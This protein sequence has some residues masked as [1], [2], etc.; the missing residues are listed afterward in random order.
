MSTLRPFRN[1][2]RRFA[3]AALLLSLA[4]V[5]V[6]HPRPADRPSI[7]LALAGGGALG[8]AHLGVILELEEL[9]IPVDYIAGTSMGSVVGALY[10]TGYSG[11]QILAILEEIDW[12]ELFMAKPPRRSL[13]YEERR[14]DK[15]YMVD[16]GIQEGAI[17][18][19]S[20]ATAGQEITELLDELLRY[21]AVSDS[22]DRF[23]RPLR[24][25]ATDLATGEEVVYSS[26]DLKTAVRA[27]MAVPGIFTPVEYQG[28]LLIDGGWSNLLP[29]DAVRAMG[30]ERV[31]AVKLNELTIDHRELMPITEVIN[32]SSS[33][34]R[35]PKQMENLA[36]ADV[37]L[38][39]DVSDYSPAS[40]QHGME[41]VEAGRQAVREK[42]PELLFLRRETLGAAAALKSIVPPTQDQLVDIRRIEY[43]GER[44]PAEERATLARRFL[45]KSWVS[46]IQSATEALYGTSRYL[47]ATYELIPEAEGVALLIHLTADQHRRTTVRGGYEFR[48]EP[49]T[50]VDPVFALRGNIGVEELTGRGSRWDTDLVV[51]ETASIRTGYEQ[52]LFAP[53]SLVTSLYVTGSPVMYYQQRKVES[54]YTRRNLGGRGGM[55]AVLFD[56]VELTAQGV[57][58]W[59]TTSHKGGTDRNLESGISQFGFTLTGA[60]DNLDRY[61]FPRRGA[62]SLAT[63]SYRYRP[64]TER[65][66]NRVDMEQTYYVPLLKAS[67]LSIGYRIASDLDTSAPASGR[68]FIGG[69][70]SFSGLHEQELAGSHAAVAS[71]TLRFNVASLPV[72]LGE[73]I[74]LT[75]RGDLGNVW[76]RELSAVLSTE[77]ELIFGTGAG[78][79]ADTIFGE[80]HFR[81]AAAAGETLNSPEV[82]YTSYLILGTSDADPPVI[83]TE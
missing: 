51:S 32:Q 42:L 55:R 30:A 74:Y 50:S 36:E 20:G 25:V 72:G 28:R 22:F 63:Y 23:P 46:E 64:E 71:A 35:L 7:G 69:F 65:A 59:V 27:S 2:L 82:R 56:S 44:P 45:G 76:E 54:Q 43:T 53:F 3:S 29:V 57:S 40:F 67:A 68:A 66:F 18:F 1:R 61:P 19:R 21:Y 49:F 4:L 15:S 33:L 48:S 80:I 75:V 39:P 11:E 83:G 13:S 10:A 77:P 58:E 60:A 5:G 17:A 9:G 16:V 52:P 24:V 81:V 62:E 26:G 70:G 37:V 12:N 14:A 73:R 78:I 38:S 41:L 47:C 79:S 34:L 8:I 6:A 31:V